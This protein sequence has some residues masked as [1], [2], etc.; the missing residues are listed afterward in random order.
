VIL[1]PRLPITNWPLIS[2][3]AA[4]AVHDAVLTACNLKVDIKW[5]NDL[6]F[7]DQKLCGILTETVETEDGSAAIV[8]MGINLTDDG[9]PPELK[10]QATS[11]QAATGTYA[12][13]DLLVNELLKA[14]TSRYETLQGDDGGEQIIRDWCENSSYA[15]GRHVRVAVGTDSFVGVTRGLER[16]GALRVEAET[17]RIVRAGDVTA[18]RAHA[19]D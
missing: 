1:R 9:F 4:L 16:D 10:L 2:L 3:A 15:F 19:G 12:D 8:G 5:P 6:C 14:L 11:L 13:R 18:L 7:N 17:I